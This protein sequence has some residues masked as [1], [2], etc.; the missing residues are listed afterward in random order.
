MPNEPCM[1]DA[2]KCYVEIF[3]RLAKENEIFHF[4]WTTM[5]KPQEEDIILTKT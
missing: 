5:R 3:K 1:S 2:N 4:N